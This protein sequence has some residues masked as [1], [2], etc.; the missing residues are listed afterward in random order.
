M[1]EINKD[2]MIDQE[3]ISAILD[4]MGDGLISTDLSGIIDFMNPEAERLT[5]WMAED[6]IG[7]QLDQVFYIENKDES[8]IVED[9]IK[10]VIQQ[11]KVVGLS[12]NSILISKIGKKSYLS[13]S[14][15]PIF[16]GSKELGVVVVF[17]DITRI[18][19]IEEALRFERNN[20]RTMFKLLPLGMAIVDEKIMIQEANQ[21]FLY[22]FDSKDDEIVGRPIGSGLKC[23]FSFSK[24]CGN[25]EHCKY[26]ELRT[27]IS[28]VQLSC[29]YPR[30][31]LILMTLYRN[32][33]QKELWCRINYIPINRHSKKHII[34]I[35][36]DV[37]D[38]VIHEENLEK[39]NR[40]CHKL[41][42]SLPLMVWKTD[43]NKRI[44]YINQTFLDFSGLSFEEAAF[45]ILDKN[46]YD[47][48]ESL[49]S[50]FDK[51]FA[52]KVG[53]EIETKVKGKDGEVHS[54]VSGGTPYYDLDDEFA[55]YICTLFDITRRKRAENKAI[56]NQKKYYSLFM[57]MESGFV[58]VKIIYDSKRNVIDGEIQ[59]INEAFGKLFN[60]RREEIIGS[61][62]SDKIIADTDYDS[63]ILSV[64]ESV[65]S[66]EKVIYQ[67]EV[68]SEECNKWIAIS[69]YSPEQGY[70][71]LLLEDIDYKYK[72][73][74][75]LEKAKEQA[76]D[77]N[78]AKSEFLANMSHE[79]RTPLNGIVGMI[80]LTLSTNI[81]KEQEGNLRLAKKCANSLLNIIN[82]I[83]DYS[84]IEA[85]K[86]VLYEK[87]FDF[88]ELIN[89]VIMM[90]I[91]HAKEKAL[92]LYEEI[93]PLLPKDLFGDPE[94][95]KQILNNL[96]SN[97][98]KF[99]QKGEVLIK[100]N[101]KLIQK[102]KITVLVSVSDTGIGISQ[103]DR[104][105]LFNSFSQ[106]DGSYTRKYGGSGLGLIICKQ[107][108]ELCGGKIW[109]ESEEGTGSTFSFTLSLKVRSNIISDREVDE[110]LL[111][112]VDKEP[113]FQVI[114]SYQNKM[115]ENYNI[116]SNIELDKNGEVVFMNQIETLIQPDLRTK[117]EEYIEEMEGAFVIDDSE[118]I[119]KNAH[120]IVTLC[121]IIGTGQLKRIAFKIELAARKDNL[122]QVK[123]FIMLLK[124]EIG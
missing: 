20:L 119:E 5:G 47:R 72:N 38:Q 50:I 104:V 76:E 25:S 93:D 44:N 34:I 53:Y 95:I 103:E 62:L 87:K 83:L 54:M 68:F 48:N 118:L 39:S 55:G 91:T 31:T 9:R 124:Q 114:Q 85:K 116:N 86:M 122:M 115:Y 74:M 1:D 82:D 23:T 7:K 51:S 111:K 121:D 21:T 32:G 16:S 109:I 58:Y 28:Q 18:R 27:Q 73:K 102:D 70:M 123:E 81:D 94:R 42:D 2:Q 89:E 90:N 6:G 52:M 63:R 69:I 49:E 112:P 84:K 15:S 22:M 57:N 19:G 61:R 108:V 107:L 60:C 10:L 24:G 26:C 65:S 66:E 71:A 101:T 14:F 59:E 13:A 33:E 36:E 97:A 96:I 4:C 78:R 35:I 117:I 105:K 8:F 79:I 46:L 100:I 56:E 92:H 88:R 120:N 80:E 77:A 45:T 110:Y 64:Y 17:R 40:S 98:L 67:K 106:L 29:E 3:R 43:I 37:N 113:L 99:T 41:L 30:N 75:E 12:K 11:R